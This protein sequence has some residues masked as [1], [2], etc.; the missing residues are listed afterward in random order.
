MHEQDAKIFFYQNEPKF[1]HQQNGGF[2]SQNE[3][4]LFHEQDA[5]FYFLRNEPKKCHEQNAGFGIQNEPK[6]Y[7][8]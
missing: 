4:K 1:L 7:F 5:G 6:A 3:P 2:D 8:N